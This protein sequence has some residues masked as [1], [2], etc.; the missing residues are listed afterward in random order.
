[1]FKSD[2][3]G[4]PR[5]CV[6]RSDCVPERNTHPFSAA[7]EASAG[8]ESSP[9]TSNEFRD[10]AKRRRGKLISG[11]MLMYRR[12]ARGHSRAEGSPGPCR[13]IYARDSEGGLLLENRCLTLRLM[14]AA[15]RSKALVRG[16][17]LFE[18]SIALHQS[19]INNDNERFRHSERC[20]SYV[21]F[22]P[23]HP[24]Q[25]ER[26]ILTALTRET[27]QSL[28]SGDLLKNEVCFLNR[29]RQRDSRME[30]A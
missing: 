18:D 12:G 27:Q 26:S 25:Q 4:A 2:L 1:M 8:G 3:R 30:E 5:P 15:E 14:G 9:A 6:Q 21:V 22:K 13:G 7:G 17:S 10:N 29:K 16:T 20:L 24:E 28:L 23:T 19:L 11:N